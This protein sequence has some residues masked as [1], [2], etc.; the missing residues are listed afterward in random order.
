MSWN[1]RIIKHQYRIKTSTGKRKK[2]TYFAIHEVYYGANN[3]YR[4][5]SLYP[6]RPVAETKKELLGTLRMYLRD[7]K[8]SYNRVINCG[9][10]CSQRKCEEFWRNR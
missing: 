4:A 1:Y 7:A 9:K 3:K 5:R 2:I 6:V 10:K 8:K